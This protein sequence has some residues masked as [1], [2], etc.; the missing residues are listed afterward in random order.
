[1]KIPKLFEKCNAIASNFFVAFQTLSLVRAEGMGG[2][3]HLI[4]GENTYIS[5]HVG[6]ASLLKPSVFMQQWFLF[7]PSTTGSQEGSYAVTNF[8]SGYTTQATPT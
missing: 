1:M 4:Y 6:R 7:E 5:G 8:D 2:H 3:T